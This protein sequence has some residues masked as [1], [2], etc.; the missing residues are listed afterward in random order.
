MWNRRRAKKFIERVMEEAPEPLDLALIVSYV[1]LTIVFYI[2][3]VVTIAQDM[4]TGLCVLF[5][6]VYAGMLFIIAMVHELYRRVERIR[7]RII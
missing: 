7:E 5:I 3:M 6:A 1:F 4:V 2:G